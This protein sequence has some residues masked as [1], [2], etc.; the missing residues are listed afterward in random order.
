MDGQTLMDGQIFPCN[1]A[2][3]AMD[4]TN[5]NIVLIWK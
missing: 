1:Y 3:N 4:G 5:E 2:Y